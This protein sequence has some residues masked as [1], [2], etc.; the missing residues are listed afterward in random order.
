MMIAP[1]FPRSDANAE[2]QAS[3]WAKFAAP[4]ELC[5]LGC[6]VGRVDEESLA[7]DLLNG[8]HGVSRRSASR[9]SGIRRGLGWVRV[10]VL[11]RRDGDRWVVGLGG[12]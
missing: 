12:G 8:R 1:L 6:G 3:Y 5:S 4:P 9:C 7:C 2:I 11:D 10:D